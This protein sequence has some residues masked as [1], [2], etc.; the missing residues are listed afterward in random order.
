[1]PVR[2]CTPGSGSGGGGHPPGAATVV[3]SVYTFIPWKPAGLE[4]HHLVRVREVLAA[5]SS[6]M[7]LK[8]LIISEREDG[9]V[10]REDRRDGIDGGENRLHVGNHLSPGGGGV[11]SGS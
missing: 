4:E 8:K 7:S 6:C 9:G 2:T 10:A 1:M 3:R 11:G 5:L